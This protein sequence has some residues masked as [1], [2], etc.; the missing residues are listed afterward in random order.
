M[1]KV[2]ATILFSLLLPAG[3][4]MAMSASDKKDDRKDD[5]KDKGHQ[6]ILIVVWEQAWTP[7][8]RE[9]SAV[10]SFET[11]LVLPEEIQ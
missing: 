1:R 6:P 11:G 10:D 8:F 9:V 4:A 3:I 7:I 5:K 2:F